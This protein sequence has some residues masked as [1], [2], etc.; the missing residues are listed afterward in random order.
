MV[1]R[2]REVLSVQPTAAWVPVAAMQFREHRDNP[3]W[4]GWIKL[5][6]LPGHLKA[7]CKST[8]NAAEANK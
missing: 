6:M 1:P 7:A 5:I 2:V 3:A 8:F 4:G